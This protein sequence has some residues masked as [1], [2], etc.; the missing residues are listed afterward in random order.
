VAD[1]LIARGIRVR[2]LDKMAAGRREYLPP[3]AELIE[4]DIRDDAAIQALSRASIACS[5]W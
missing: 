2:V 4:A 3:A 1:A 5:T